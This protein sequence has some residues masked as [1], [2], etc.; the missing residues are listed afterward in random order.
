MSRQTRTRR[1]RNCPDSPQAPVLPKSKPAQ[2][3]QKPASVLSQRL[4]DDESEGLR[5]WNHVLFGTKTC[6]DMIDGYANLDMPGDP[7]QKIR[8]LIASL[9]TTLNK[10]ESKHANPCPSD[11]RPDCPPDCPSP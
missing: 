6:C 11:R 9:T 8:E 10:L 2:T 5:L 3:E 4:I 1:C 7:R